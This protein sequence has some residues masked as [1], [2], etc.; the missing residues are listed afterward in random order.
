MNKGFLNGL[1]F[2]S[3][4]FSMFVDSLVAHPKNGFFIEGGFETGLLQTKETL[5]RQKAISSQPSPKLLPF[6]SKTSSTDVW[7]PQNV[8]YGTS[9]FSTK[10]PIKFFINENNGV[11]TLGIKNYLPYDLYNVYLK[12]KNANGS[13]TTIAGIKEIGAYQEVSF[14]VSELDS[15]EIDSLQSSWADATQLSLDASQFSD[16]TTQATLNAFK[17][18]SVDIN[19][20]FAGLEKSVIDTKNI[21]VQEAKD[22][23]NIFYDYAAVLSSNEWA[24]AILNYPGVFTDERFP[25]LNNN[26]QSIIENYR[27]EIDLFLGVLSQNETSKGFNGLTGK[28]YDSAYMGIRLQTIDPTTDTFLTNFDLSNENERKL[29]GTLI[30]EFGHAKGYSHYGNMTC[31]NGNV[32]GTETCSNDNQTIEHNGKTYYSGMVGQTEQVWAELGKANKLPINYN[33]IGK[34]TAPNTKE[35]ADFKNSLLNQTSMLLNQLTSTISSS[36]TTKINLGTKNYNLAMLGFNVKSGYLYYFND[37]VGLSAYGIIKYNYS[38]NPNAIVKKV[39]QVGLGVGGDILIDFLTLYDTSKNAN[40]KRIFKSSAG[41]SLGLR[42]L[43]NGYGFYNT[44]HNTGNL[45]F[46]TAINYRYKHLKYSIGIAI[47]L[48]QQ[49]LKTRLKIP[50]YQGKFTLNEGAS[51]FNIYFNM[52]WV[53]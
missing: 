35:N 10:R 40:A 44:F 19:G 51:H 15:K 46:N 20:S 38:Q 47:P 25:N 29:L 31:P 28:K 5:T 22:F 14:N 32:G 49:H 53:F 52:G 45:D 17:N 37:Y 30:H 36:Q 6:I 13:E 39:Q 11:K 34:Q 41:I 3:M 27:K 24:E 9:G 26:R 43:Y 33:T 50:N 48:V 23:A 18:M 21:S 7:T 2:K 16:T 12:I 8:S 1:Y 42:A 4:F